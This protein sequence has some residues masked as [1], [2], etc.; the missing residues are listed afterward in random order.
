MSLDL[1][2]FRPDG[3]DLPPRALPVMCTACNTDRH[4]TITSVTHPPDQPADVVVVS[5]TCSRCGQFSEHPAW[6][7]ELSLVL[8]RLGQT[9][10]VLILGGHYMHC[11]QPMERRHSELRRL[12]APLSTEDTAEDELEVYLSTRVLRCACGFQMELP[13]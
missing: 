12:A 5:H 6:V 3:A 8:A 2:A 10:D 13:E 9:D 7:A 1:S 4:L 11:G